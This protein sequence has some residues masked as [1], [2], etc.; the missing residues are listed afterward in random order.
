MVFRR[1]PARRLPRVRRDPAGSGGSGG[2][3]EAAWGGGAA[4]PGGG[5]RRGRR[6]ASGGGFLWRRRLVARAAG[7]GVGNEVA[8]RG[9]YRLEGGVRLGEGGDPGRRRRRRPGL[10]RESGSATIRAKRRGRWAGWAFGPVRSAG[11]FFKITPN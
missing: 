7:F 4:G 6:E 11:D 5:W 3:R 10:R 2:V 8:G 9:T 1:K